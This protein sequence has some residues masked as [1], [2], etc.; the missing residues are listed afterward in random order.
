M[1]ENEQQS[2]EIMA[3]IRGKDFLIDEVKK[4]TKKK[5]ASPPFTTSYLQQAASSRLGFTAKRTMLI[6]QQLYE[7][8]ELKR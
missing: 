3:G 7:G 6:A 8:V 4:G 5:S 1:I 2:D